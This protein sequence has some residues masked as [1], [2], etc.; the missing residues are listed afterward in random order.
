MWFLIG[1]PTIRFLRSPTPCASYR[2]LSKCIIYRYTHIGLYIETLIAAYRH[3]ILWSF[4][5]TVYLTFILLIPHRVLCLS[6]S[7]QW[8]NNKNSMKHKAEEEN[9]QPRE[10][11][12]FH[13]FHAIFQSQL[14]D[15]YE[16]HYVLCQNKTFYAPFNITNGAVSFILLCFPIHQ[17]ECASFVQ[18]LYICYPF[19]QRHIVSID[20]QN[21]N[22]RCCW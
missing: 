17:C 2:T 9:N 19:I 13:H 7:M 11:N 22:I 20:F 14:K 18:K 15:D 1:H 5:Y 6:F 21:K 8:N 12:L 16:N 10:K 4:D 3:Q